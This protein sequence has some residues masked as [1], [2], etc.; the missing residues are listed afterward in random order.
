MKKRTY[1][2]MKTILIFSLAYPIYA[3]PTATDSI[4]RGIASW[5]GGSERLNKHTANGEV[6]NPQHLTCASWHYP[7]NTTL[8]VTNSADGRSITVRVNDRGPNKRLGRVIDLTRHAFS[9]IA[10]TRQG[11]I[12]VKIEKVE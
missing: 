2:I 10:D 1:V 4:T 8:K 5:Y 7:F 3:W 12:L 11:L 9:R 6:F